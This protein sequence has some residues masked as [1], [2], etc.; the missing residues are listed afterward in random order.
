MNFWE[1]RRVFITGCTGFLGSWLTAELLE[2]GAQVVG[3]VRIREPESELVR[4][5]LI[6]EIIQVS[7]ELLDIALLRQTLKAYHIDT[8]FHL[9]GQT[10]VGVANR[11]PVATF[12][13]N[14]RGTWLLLEAVRETPSVRSTII[15]SSE[16]AYGEQ[17]Q[18]PYMEESPLLGRHPYEVSKGCADLI[19]RSYAHTYGL[20]IAV[21][22]CSNLYGGGDLSWNRLIPGT[23]RSVLSG[24]R[25][26][27]RSDGTFRRDYLY[28][29]DAVRAYLMLA[30]QLTRPD[31]RGEAFNIGSGNPVSALEVVQTIVRISGRIDLEP[32]ILNEVKN[33]IQDEYLCPDKAMDR[34]GWLPR[35]PLDNGIRE[36]MAWY[37][38]YLNR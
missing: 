34:I 27:I 9:A 32:V 10:I 29:A 35:Y 15:A 37:E 20:S 18:L 8:V 7:G 23:I 3:L 1:G 36:T 25:P 26:V 19:A 11:D 5:G 12:E 17:V 4:T 21:T 28:V 31:V 6:Q 2:R 13:T 30:E 16:K 24:D 33:E 22:R 14:V 38:A